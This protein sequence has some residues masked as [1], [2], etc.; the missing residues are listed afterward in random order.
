MWLK[1]RCPRCGSEVRLEYADSSIYD[2][3]CPQCGGEFCLFVRKPKFEVLFDMG[4]QALLDGY[5]REAVASFAAAQERFFEFYIRAASLERATGTEQSMEEA[6][7]AFESTWK[8]VVSQTERQTGMLA[9]A[10]LMRE[11]RPLSS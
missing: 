2:A 9:L 6:A 5:A 11:G 1:T 7:S 3:A 10:Y 4:A 8:H